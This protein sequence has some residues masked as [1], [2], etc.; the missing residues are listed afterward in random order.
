MVVKNQIL[1]CLLITLY[2]FQTSF[3]FNE[4]GSIVSILTIMETTDW[5]IREGKGKDFIK[6]H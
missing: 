2:T 1:M 4:T 3:F 6:S 5:M